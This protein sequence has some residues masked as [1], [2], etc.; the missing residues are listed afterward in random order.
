MYELRFTKPFDT[1]YL[2]LL[3]KEKALIKNVDKALKQLQENPFYTSLKSH[4]TYTRNYG[5]RWSS[6]VTGDVRIILDF[7]K[8]LI[9]TIIL[10]DIGKHSGAQK[11]YR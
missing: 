5:V 3:R 2:R 6:W 8:E 1:S 7:D 4:K 11:V 10:L 9:L